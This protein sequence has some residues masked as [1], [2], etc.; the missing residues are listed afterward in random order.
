MICDTDILPLSAGYRFYSVKGGPRCKKAT[1]LNRLSIYTEFT[2]IKIR[3]LHISW[4]R[5]L[6]CHTWVS[7]T[8]NFNPA[9]ATHNGNRYRAF[10]RGVIHL[11]SI[12]V[13]TAT[14]N[15][16]NLHS[17]CLYRCYVV[18]VSS[19]TFKVCI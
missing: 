15:S 14:K 17:M 6:S 10:S 18:F 13:K 4:F 3:E 8:V 12:L 1:I 16:E 7:F 2:L 5:H 9:G 19:E 11:L